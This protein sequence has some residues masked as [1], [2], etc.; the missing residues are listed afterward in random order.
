M[1]LEQCHSGV[2]GGHFS[3][4]TTAA[5]FLHACY[6]CPSL[7][8]D[9]H[10][11]IRKCKACQCFTGKKKLVSLPLRPIEVQVP[12]SRW[13]M[14]FIGPV[15]P[16]SSNGHIFILTT[17]DYFTKWAEA[18]SLRNATSQQV[19]EFVEHN[20]LSHF[21]TPT[22]ILT[23]N[24]SGFMYDFMLHLGVTYGIQIF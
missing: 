10:L 23:D 22:K 20:I 7:H 12:F 4:K 1:A 19:V 18:I 16:S 24:G 13:G 3:T 14:D 21:G 9:A 8:Q 5:K 6:F 15:S 11:L 2:C 17:T